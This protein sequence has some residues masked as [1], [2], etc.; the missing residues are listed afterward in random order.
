MYIYAQEEI[1]Q[2]PSMYIRQSYGDRLQDNLD[3]GI[4]G[5]ET[6]SMVQVKP[7][8]VTE[9]SGTENNQPENAN[10]EVVNIVDDKYF[11]MTKKELVLG[12]ILGVATGYFIYTKI[13][14]K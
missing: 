4:D 10:N 7:E 3:Y 8:L 13:I 12:V 2:S 9:N 11:G 1:M 14:K 5:E 6:R